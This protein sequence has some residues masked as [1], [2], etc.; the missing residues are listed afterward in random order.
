M[1]EYH[2]IFDGN[3]EKRFE[4]YCKLNRIS[5]AEGFRNLCEL[6]LHNLEINKQI[7]LNSLLLSKIYSKEIYIR[8]LI[9]QL[10]SDIGIESVSNPK[11]NNA[12]QDFKKK[13]NKDNLDD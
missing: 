4:D 7:E 3:L 1:K 8:D 13:H 2:P 9:E 11:K 12:L 6:G 10:Y 5:Y